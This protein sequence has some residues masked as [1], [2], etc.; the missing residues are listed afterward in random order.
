MPK[1]FQQLNAETPFIKELK[2]AGLS[3]AIIFTKEEL[4][5]FG[6]AYLDRVDLSKACPIKKNI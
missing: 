6:L 5:R 1:T 3:Y 2:K 4:D